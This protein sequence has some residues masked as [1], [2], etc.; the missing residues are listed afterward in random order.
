MLHKIEQLLSRSDDDRVTDISDEILISFGT[1][2]KG[3][4][5]GL[6]SQKQ[7]SGTFYLRAS[8]IGKDTRQLYLDSKYGRKPLTPQEQV[9]MAYGHLIEELFI[10]LGQIAG[11]DV[12]RG[13][14]SSTDIE[15]ITIAGTPDIIVDGEIKDIKTAS[16]FSYKNKFTTLDDMMKEGNDSFGYVGQAYCYQDMDGIPYTGWYVINKVT[17]DWKEVECDPLKLQEI[18]PKLERNV[19]VVT[20]KEEPPPCPG[21]IKEVFNRKETG[22]WIL[23]PEC[24]FC[25]HKDKCGHGTITELPNVNSKAQDPIIQFYVGEVKIPQ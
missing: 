6:V 24:R 20:G 10:H 16:D 3:I 9:K 2:C 7:S 8:N 19:R 22:N 14:T 23:P 4:L 12:V 11:A 15:G 25:N 17:G 1:R 21:P 18:R 5:K 13:S